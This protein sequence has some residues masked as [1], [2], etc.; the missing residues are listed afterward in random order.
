MSYAGVSE[1]SMRP[2]NMLHDRPRSGESL[3]M[4]GSNFYSEDC[5]E[6]DVLESKFSR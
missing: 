5:R 4:R 3:V 6:N 1:S 2:V